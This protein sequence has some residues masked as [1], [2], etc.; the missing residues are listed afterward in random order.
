MTL[1]AAKTWEADL[2]AADQAHR[3]DPERL[4]YLR[5][6]DESPLQGLHGRLRFS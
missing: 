6:L 5:S 4:A 3:C 1:I 2:E